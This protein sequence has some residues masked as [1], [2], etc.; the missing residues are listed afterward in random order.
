MLAC[1]PA[2]SWNLIVRQH[3]HIALDSSVKNRTPLTSM[4][5]L[6]AFTLA[7][8]LNYILRG[9]DVCLVCILIIRNGSCKQHIYQRRTLYYVT[10]YAVGEFYLAGN[11]C[12][13]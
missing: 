9:E 10:I 12:I 7:V 2:D 13:L 3:V 4:T 11:K 8:Y 5:R 6:M 1:L